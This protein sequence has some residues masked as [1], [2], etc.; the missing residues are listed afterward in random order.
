MQIIS[1]HRL[2][3]VVD[4]KEFTTAG[5]NTTEDAPDWI[6]EDQYF[7]MN[8]TAGRITRVGITKPETLGDAPA[9]KGKG[10]GG[11]KAKEAEAP[12]VE[13]TELAEA[14]LEDALEG[15]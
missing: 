15:V 4:H 13:E 2:T 8:E 5:R 3:F 10:K 7:T 14:E 11:K 6:V 1:T 12:E 9:P